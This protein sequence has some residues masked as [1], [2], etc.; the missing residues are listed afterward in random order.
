[1]FQGG[2][3][4]SYCYSDIEND[5]RLI[6]QRYDFCEIFSI[7][8]SVEKR[9]L[10]ALKIGNGKKRI[11]INA[12]HHALEY[13]TSAALMRFID[14]Y[15]CHIKHN[16]DFF[17]YSVSELYERVSL[18]CV[19]MVNPDGVELSI[20]GADM[21]NPYHRNIISQTGLH[22]FSGIWQAN[23]N[24]VDLNHN[25]DADWK[26]VKKA[27]SPTR[28]GGLYPESEPEV[29]AVVNF[30]RSIPF[31][32]VIA[33]HSQGREIYYDFKNLTASRSFEIAQKMADASGY[34]V[35][36]PSGIASFGGFKDWFIKEYSK[37]GFTIEICI[38]KN[39]IPV[40]MLDNEYESIAKII[41]T[42]LGEV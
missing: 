35:S 26:S 4:M 1:M 25:Y 13:I 38:G 19:P 2:G 33:L 32:M 16:E 36:E 29:K 23:I 6:A 27:P 22:C 21:D 41:L 28:Y 8:E 37:E 42:A 39:P 11:F 30:V 7:G 15:C 20:K 34:T 18:Y 5:T 10:Y 40:C 17:G 9:K 12:A 24:G 31:D 3:K 14:D